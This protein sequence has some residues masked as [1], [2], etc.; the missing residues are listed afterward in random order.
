MFSASCDVVSE[1]GQDILQCGTYDK[2]GARILAPVTRYLGAN[3]SVAFEV[4]DAGGYNRIGRFASFELANASLGDYESHFIQNDPVYQLAIRS[5][6]GAPALRKLSLIRLS[7]VTNEREFHRTDF[8]N[9]FK[10]PLCI[11][12]QL[13]VVVRPDERLRRSFVFCFHRSSARQPFGDSDAARLAPLGPYLYAYAGGLL[14][15]DQVSWH[16]EVVD[17]LVRAS[18]DIGVIVLDTRYELRYCNAQGQRYL[19]AGVCPS[20]MHDAFAAMCRRLA[21]SNLT[22]GVTENLA[23]LPGSAGHIDGIV[24]VQSLCTANGERHFLIAVRPFAIESA[25][26][27]RCKAL[28]W[29]RR[30]VEVVQLIIGGGTTH[31]IAHRL[32]VSE[33]T[34]ENHLRGIFRKARVHSRTQLIHQVLSQSA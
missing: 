15:Q 2:I 8:Y 27:N 22:E 24:T 29:T 23:A 14:L 31:Q 34:I 21:E 32:G 9:N 16:E 28:G 26:R 10:K 20:G 1:L 25:L 4:I 33:H 11:H 18:P 17:A 13:S 5:R 6:D 12:D 7:E 19:Q 3:T 30:E